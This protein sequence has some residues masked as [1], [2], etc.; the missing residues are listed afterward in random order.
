M[1]KRE[2]SLVGVLL[3]GLVLGISSI[4][5]AEIQ[6]FF[7]L[8]TPENALRSLREARIFNGPEEVM[9]CLSQEYSKEERALLA[10]RFYLDFRKLILTGKSGEAFEKHMQHQRILDQYYY[11][12]MQIDADEYVVWW[13]MSGDY[14]VSEPYLAVREGLE[15]KIKIKFLEY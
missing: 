2:I 13:E 3:L 15:W 5:M 4:A 8:S 10:V 7:D 6:P 12:R 11:K 14:V 9:Q 1:K